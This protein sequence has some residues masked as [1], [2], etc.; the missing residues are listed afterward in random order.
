MCSVLGYCGRNGEY[1]EV[2]KALL[3]TKSRGPDDSRVIN[4][5]NGWIGFNRLSIMGLT[6]SG[7]QPFVYGNRA[8][9]VRPD[10]KE[11]S[12]GYVVPDEGELV[13]ACNGEIYGFRPLKEELVKKGYSFISD[14]DCE[15]LPALYRE[16]G[17]DMFCMLDAEFALILYD[18]KEDSYIAARDPIG[19]RPLYYGIREDGTYV[20][21]SE[22]KNLTS[23]VKRIMPFPPGYYFK[24]GVFSKYREMAKPV[25]FHNEDLPELSVNVFVRETA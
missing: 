20:F 17:T 13:L 19:I 2:L 25:S 24:D 4:T 9:C 16:Y 23:L 10:L 3:E 5:G 6:E 11:G 21:A 7:M 15:I 14:S 22:P 12:E 18:R 8:T 1:N